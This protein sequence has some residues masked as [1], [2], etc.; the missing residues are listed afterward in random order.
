MKGMRHRTTISPDPAPRLP[1]ARNCLGLCVAMLAVLQTGCSVTKSPRMENLNSTPALAGLGTIGVTATSTVP[2]FTVLEPLNRNEAGEATARRIVFLGGDAF[3]DD[4]SML[5]SSLTIGLSPFVLSAVA[6]P[7]RVV[8]E[9]LAMPEKSRVQANSSLQRTISNLNFQDELRTRVVQRTA[10]RAANPIELVPKPFP[11]GR[12]EEFSRMS[13][14]MAGTL[15]WLPRGQTAADYLTSQGVDTVLEIQLIHPGLKGSGKIN[16]PL[17]LCVEVRA[18]LL[19]AG[20]G[21]ELW[22]CAAQY[23]SAKH[24]FTKWAD[25]EARLFRRELD[26]CFDSLAEQIAGQLFRSP[27]GDAG[28]LLAKT[29]RQSP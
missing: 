18:R 8:A 19:E 1:R 29:A 21:R 27:A 25:E 12:E 26:R 9:G 22:Q 15:A 28:H 20:S 23:R 7:S 13:C 24:K 6:V 11:P 10:A 3:T 4:V 14:V 17:A 16:P 2:K 5:V